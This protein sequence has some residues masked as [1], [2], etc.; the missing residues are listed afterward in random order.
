MPF[1]S[2][3]SQKY[4]WRTFGIRYGLALVGGTV[5]LVLA[6]L[7]FKVSRVQYIVIESNRLINVGAPTEALARLDDISG[8]TDMHP[9]LS[10]NRKCA[11]CIIPRLRGR[12]RSRSVRDVVREVRT[13][14]DAGVREVNLISQDSTAYGRDR[15]DRSSLAKVLRAVADVRGIEWVRVL[16]LY[17][18]RF[19]DEL[20]SLVREVAPRTLIPVHTENPGYFREALVATD[21]E[22]MEPE[23]GR[24]IALD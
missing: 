2:V 15:Q 17:P 20:L 5:V 10:C 19:P 18:E 22:V 11:F 13:L 16:Y 6:T 1:Q 8:W 23:Y 21:I 9:V 4:N 24:P 14:A 7:Y 12:Q 3:F